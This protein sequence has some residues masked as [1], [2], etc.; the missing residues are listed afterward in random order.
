MIIMLV[1]LHIYIK[2][3]LVLVDQSWLREEIQISKYLIIATSFKS[4][5]VKV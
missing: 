1:C 2:G 5:T 3:S 4:K